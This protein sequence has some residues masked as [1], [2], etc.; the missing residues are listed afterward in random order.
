MWFRQGIAEHPFAPL[1]RL[2][3]ALLVGCHFAI[4]SF[5]VLRQNV[6]A[7]EF[8][9]KLADPAPADGAVKAFIDCLTDG[10]GKL[11]FHTLSYT[12]YTRIRISSLTRTRGRDLAPIDSEERPQ[13]NPLLH[14]RPTFQG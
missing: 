3:F 8:L 7:R 6:R 4:G 12:Y 13:Y 1:Q 5:G 10:Y 11:P 2:L 9:D 14:R